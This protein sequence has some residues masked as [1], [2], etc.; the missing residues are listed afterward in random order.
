MLNV[1]CSMGA[2]ERGRYDHHGHLDGTM[3]TGEDI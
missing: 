1:E 2:K 3:P